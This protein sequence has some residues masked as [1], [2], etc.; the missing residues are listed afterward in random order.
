MLKYYGRSVK[1]YYDVV[2][3]VMLYYATIGKNYGI[4]GKRGEKKILTDGLKVKSFWFVDKEIEIGGEWHD[5]IIVINGKM[6]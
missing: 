1:E 5:S 3:A 6:V 2:Y 4:S